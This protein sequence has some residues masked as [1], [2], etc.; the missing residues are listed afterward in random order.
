MAAQVASSVEHV[1]HGISSGESSRGHHALLNTPL[2]TPPVIST[3]VPE[4][5][6]FPPATGNRVEVPLM[7]Y[8]L[9]GALRQAQCLPSSAKL[10]IPRSKV[11]EDMIAQMKRQDT[12]PSMVVYIEHAE[13]TVPSEEPLDYEDSKINH[14]LFMLLAA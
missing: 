3:S 2:G 10:T 4:E 6:A 9:L 1:A 8:C 14:G 7:C 12:M 5:H 13:H 11:V